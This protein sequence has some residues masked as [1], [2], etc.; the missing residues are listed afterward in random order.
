MKT[1][2]TLLLFVLIGVFPAQAA[3][4]IENFKEI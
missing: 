2:S 4:K 3:E 1:I